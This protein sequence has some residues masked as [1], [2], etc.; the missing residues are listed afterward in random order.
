MKI[1]HTHPDVGQIIEELGE[2][3]VTMTELLVIRLFNNAMN[4]DRPSLE[5]IA[6]YLGTNG[7]PITKRQFLARYREIEKAS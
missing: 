4:G 3:N 1:D 7:K 6:P 5:V 2:D